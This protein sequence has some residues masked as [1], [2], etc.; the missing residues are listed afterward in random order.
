MGRS[1][2]LISF[3][4]VDVIENIKIDIEEKVVDNCVFIVVENIKADD[5]EV[6]DMCE[7]LV[8]INFLEKV[9]NFEL[10]KLIKIYDFHLLHIQQDYLHS[11]YL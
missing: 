8:C 9:D 3:H 4:I 7:T 6:V 2:N 1:L 11:H 10:G 5:I